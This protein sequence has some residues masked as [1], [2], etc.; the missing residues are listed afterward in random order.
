MSNETYD[1]AIGE[2]ITADDK[3]TGDVISRWVLVAETIDADTGHRC[4][5]T[6]VS[7]G[8]TDWDIIGLTGWANARAQSGA[9]QD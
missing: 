7:E 5:V 3:C 9:H 6:R 4:L 8:T 2:A 1:K